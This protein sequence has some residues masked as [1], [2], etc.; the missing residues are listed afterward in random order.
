[1]Q[2][3]DLLKGLSLALGGAVST[4]CQQA[5]KVPQAQRH[6][7]PMAYSETQRAVAH[8]VADLIL[9][10]TDTPGALDAG[11]G[12]FI[13]YVVAQWY[14]PAERSR[15]LSGLDWLDEQALDRYGRAYLQLDPASRTE[16]L[17]ARE[18]LE[19]AATRGLSE[20]GSGDF[21]AQIKELTVVGFYT[22]KVGATEARH[23]L[24]MPG[25]Y[26]GHYRFADTE[27]QWST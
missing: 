3:R 8:T 11:V 21:F 5:L 22:S 2:R 14:S 27:K 24:P 15:F 18:D 12:Q 17:S 19:A 23:Y 6:V 1:V 26:D 13:D 25:R 4:A 9:P 7:G 20:F 16:L 10:A